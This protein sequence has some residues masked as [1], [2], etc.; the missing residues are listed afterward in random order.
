MHTLVTGAPES[1]T[2]SE[3]SKKEVVN[4]KDASMLGSICDMEIDVFN[5]NVKAIILPGGGMFA[6]LSQKNRI[7][8]PWRDV[9]RIGDDAILVKYFP[10]DECGK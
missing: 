8:I 1:A 2:L 10:P 7:T 3:L 9:V 4:I 5:G 6:S